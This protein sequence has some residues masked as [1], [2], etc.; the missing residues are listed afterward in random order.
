[1]FP[2]VCLAAMADAAVVF[3]QYADGPDAGIPSLFLKYQKED[4]GAR[5][6][7]TVRLS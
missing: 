1:M 6:M 5:G 2:S 4:E 3:I 7:A